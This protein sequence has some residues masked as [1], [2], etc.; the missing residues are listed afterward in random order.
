MT[1][2]DDHKGE[3]P[4]DFSE[5]TDKWGYLNNSE[6]SGENASQDFCA[7]VGLEFD[8]TVQHNPC[9]HWHRLESASLKS[10]PFAA[11]KWVAAMSQVGTPYIYVYDI[12]YKAVIKIETSTA[13]T[14]PIVIENLALES[15]YDLDYGTGTQKGGYCINEDSTTLW[16]M[17]REVSGDCQLIEVDISGTTMSIVKKTTFSGLNAE[18]IQDGCANNS[19]VFWA[20]EKID[21]RIIKIAITDHSILD[22]HL[23]GF[24]LP[25]CAGNLEGIRN[26]AIDGSNLYWNYV[27]DYTSCSPPIYYNA[28]THHIISDLDFG[29]IVELL[30]FGSGASTP[31]WQNMLRVYNNQVFQHRSYHPSDGPIARRDIGTLISSGSINMQY[32]RNIF[33]L[34]S[35]RLFTIMHINNPSL[36][37]R[38]YC[39]DSNTMT[40]IVYVDVSSYAGQPSGYDWDPTYVSAMNVQN[41]VILLFRYNNIES[42]NYAA[43]FKADNSLDFICDT[44]LGFKMV[45]DIIG[46]ASL[47]SAEPQVWPMN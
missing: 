38:I 28:G 7:S 47:I 14:P 42:K 13:P 29:I 16:Y 24:N 4:W 25:A 37:T 20:V 35:F 41:R 34:V 31:Q 43:S 23:F 32:L 22:D 9:G 21:G 17:F 10:E 44:A 36:A 26:I 11:G 27:R 3:G 30:E 12:V 45:P 19:Y 39:I 46:N 8:K 15:L 1:W 18:E 5:Q 40:S 33:G 6:W 2:I